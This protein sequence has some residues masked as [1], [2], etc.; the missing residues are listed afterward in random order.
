MNNPLLNGSPQSPTTGQ[1][2]TLEVEIV[3][4]IAQQSTTREQYRALP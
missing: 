2:P 4:T 1:G 3:M